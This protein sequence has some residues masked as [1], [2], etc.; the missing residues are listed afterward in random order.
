V[1]SFPTNFIAG[2]FGFEKR[3][4]FEAPEAAEQAP[5]IDFGTRNN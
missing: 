5:V 4:Y 1:R 3:D 2:M